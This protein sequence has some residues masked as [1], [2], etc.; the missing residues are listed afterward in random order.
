[1]RATLSR[2]A[3]PVALMGLIYWLS[4]QP[5]LSSGLGGWDLV[6]RK[7][8]HMT[9]YGLLWLLW[10]RALGWSAT[11][12]LAAAAIA[13]G[14]AA[15]DELHQTTVQGRHGTPVDVLIDAVGVAIAFAL[16]RAWTA[17]RRATTA[18]RARWR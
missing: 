4:A 16:W 1:L 15:T 6:L 12:R 14:Y 13:I 2:F 8:A 10:A 18:S 17:R 11:A 5:D 9:E 7:C 3:P